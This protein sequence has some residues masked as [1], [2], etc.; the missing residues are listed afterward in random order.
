MNNV[1]AQICDQKRQHI[2]WC[3]Q[4]RPI[5]AIQAAAEKSSPPRGFIKALQIASQSS[6]GLIAEIKKSSPSKGLIRHDFDPEILDKLE[7]DILDLI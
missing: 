2:Q 4:K 7:K 3:K 5:K 6:Y 1:L